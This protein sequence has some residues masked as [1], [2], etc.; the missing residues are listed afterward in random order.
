[1]KLYF[2]LTGSVL[3]I[4]ILLSPLPSYG[5]NSDYFSGDISG[6][7][8]LIDSGN[9]LNPSSSKEVITDLDSPADR[10]LS[11]IP[12][13]VPN[14]RYTSENGIYYHLTT[15]PPVQ[16][17]GALSFG[18]GIGKNIEGIGITEIGVFAS[19]FGEV[20]ENPYLVGSPREET[21]NQKYGTY[22]RWNKILGTRAQ[23]TA[24]YYADNVDDDTIGMLEPDLER[25]GQSY[26]VEAGY[27]F[28]LGPSFMLLPKV[29]ISSGDYDGDANSY[30]R[31]TAN[32][33]ARIRLGKLSIMPTISYSKTD[34]DEIHPFF[35]RTREE[36][37][38]SF[39]L[40]L[41][42]ES[43]FGMQ[44]YSI[45]SFLG[46]GESDAN[47]DFFDTESLSGGVSISYRF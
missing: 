21:D 45:Q 28:P 41:K 38:Y 33:V 32:L 10:E 34:Y 14:L 47:I 13:I 23:F 9:N 43:P 18:L 46:V 25:D 12:L 39:S 27:A 31:Y 7:I 26:G 22:L 20:W 8:I 3:G 42:Y 1:M 24:F 30:Y 36:D 40:H 5:E 6:G 35:E 4:A 17:V 29:A 44:K 19:P 15:R 2:N 37:E 11:T 16:E